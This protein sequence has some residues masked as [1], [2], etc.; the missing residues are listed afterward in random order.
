[1]HYSSH[2]LSNF[3]QIEYETVRGHLNI[4]YQIKSSIQMFEC[5]ISNIKL[6]PTFKFEYRILN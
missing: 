2:G 5:R 3:G 6:K 1:M 4:E